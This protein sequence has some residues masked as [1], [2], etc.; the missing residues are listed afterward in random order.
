MFHLINNHKDGLNKYD[1]MS[2]L[3]N[4]GEDIEE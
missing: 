2:F 4:L 3:N 1:I